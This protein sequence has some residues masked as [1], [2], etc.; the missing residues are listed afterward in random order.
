MTVLG[1][2]VGPLRICQIS[3]LTGASS[4]SE[5]SQTTHNLEETNYIALLGLMKQLCDIATHADE[6]FAGLH[7]IAKDTVER[8]KVIHKKVTYLN[9]C[10]NNGSPLQQDGKQNM[11]PGVIVKQQS[12]FAKSTR[13]GNVKD[14]YESSESKPPL[15]EFV[16]YISLDEMDRSIHPHKLYSDP[17]LFFNAWVDLMEKESE[18]F[19]KARKR[20]FKK[21]KEDHPG[22]KIA[23]LKKK[24]HDPKS[25]TYVMV[26]VA[27]HYATLPLRG[28]DEAEE[29]SH[30]A[31]LNRK[32]YGDPQPKAALS[33]EPSSRSPTS[34]S[35]DGYFSPGHQPATSADTSRVYRQCTSTPMTSSPKN[36]DN[37]QSDH[38]DVNQ[39]SLEMKPNKPSSAPPP[40]PL[41]PTLP[42]SLPA[43][44]PPSSRSIPENSPP[45]FLPPPVPE[46]VI[47]P[48]EL[49]AMQRV[50]R[51]NAVP[52]VM[53]RDVLLE[54]IRSSSFNLKPVSLNQRPKTKLSEPTYA[55]YSG[56][57]VASILQRRK[58]LMQDNSDFSD[59]DSDTEGWE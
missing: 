8:T 57:D 22:G 39:I 32:K 28:I 15:H 14:Y 50:L 59:S 26:D 35:Q 45:P 40:P 34:S 13:P 43:T 20:S 1:R 27:P 19:K 18:Q 58:Y 56:K 52:Q 46:L 31:T 41:P 36:T 10:L 16:D 11:G 33:P 3:H 44:S 53:E 9:E 21:G 4:T 54:M 12:I 55:T 25:K 6:I 23:T 47:K 24:V 37:T 38:L 29:R 5:L 30:S 42:P 51:T 49:T 17:A 48:P 2:N 7:K